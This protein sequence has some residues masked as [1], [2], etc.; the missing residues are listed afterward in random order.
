MLTQ[1]GRLLPDGRHG[2]TIVRA[3][4]IRVAGYSDP[5]ERRRA[6]GY[7][8]RREP[9]VTESQQRAFWRWLQPLVGRIDAVMVHSPALAALALDEL[10]ASPPAAPL[11]F[12]TGHTHEQALIESEHVVVLNGGTVGGGGAGNFHENQPY[13][14]AILT[15]ESQ[16]SFEP[17][18]ADLVR[19]D[20]PEGSAQAE[21][22][23]LD[24]R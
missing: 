10:R 5:F 3:G 8:A 2:P 22:H 14:L 18:A 16:P 12:L 1:R 20:A 13:G 11:M 15:Y 9:D 21:R 17:L 23:L 19:I 6:D 7:R 24:G 4:G